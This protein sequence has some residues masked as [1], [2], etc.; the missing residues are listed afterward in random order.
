MNREIM[1]QALDAF[2]AIMFERNAESCQ[3]IAE[4]ARYTLR[5]AP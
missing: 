3:I 1:Q 2:E 4:N 5:Q